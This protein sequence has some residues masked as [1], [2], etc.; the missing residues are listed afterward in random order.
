MHYCEIAAEA[1][2]EE[3]FRL[4]GAV[5]DASTYLALTELLIDRFPDV[6]L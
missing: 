6:L 3:E 4:T 1:T 5:L 2:G